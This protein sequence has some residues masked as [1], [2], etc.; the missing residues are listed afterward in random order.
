MVIHV[1]ERGDTLRS[2][3]QR[4]GV[5]VQRLMA[6]NGLTA[7]STLAVGQAL[8]VVLP[9]ETV[10]VQPGDTLFSIAAAQGVSVLTLLQNNPEL[11]AETALRPGQ[12]L[13]VSFKG[14]K[15][16]TI[17]TGGY[18]YPFID[19]DLLKRTL[20]LLTF[21]WIFSYGFEEDG[22]LLP[23]DDEE[24]IRLARENR[25]APILVLT[26][27]TREGEFSSDKA[28]R[29]LTDEALQ[30]KLLE[31]L[32]ALLLEKG[33]AGMDMDFEY[34][35]PENAAEYAAFLRKAGEK[36]RAS[37][38][39]LT[40]ALAPKTYAG[41]PGLLYEAHDYPALGAAAD[42]AFLMTYEW[43]YAYG[44]PMAVAPLPQARQVAEYAVQEIPREKLLLGI[45]N[46]G[47]DWTLPWVEGSRAVTMGNEAAVRLAARMGAEIYYDE[48]AR[49]PYFYYLAE[50]REHLVWFEDVRSVEEKLRLSDELGLAGVGYWNLMRPFQQN[51]TLLAV[52]YEIKKLL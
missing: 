23:T 32:V 26:S 52:R 21:L 30:D 9:M 42:Y 41:Q 19:K 46:Y 31:N 3:A 27:I 2:I 45:P 12:T 1:V 50:G 4:Y 44:P 48:T 5:S 40:V 47:Y 33:Y 37:G 38:L 7:V 17:L 14:G 16:R 28:Q 29:L 8:I 20:P 36:L 34:I 22:S 35:P 25:A 39:L 49:A 18:A 43:G 10:T 51:W 11:T 24:L 15:R 6:D 13:T